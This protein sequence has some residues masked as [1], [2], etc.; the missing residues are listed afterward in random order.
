M[1]SETGDNQA[2]QSKNAVDNAE[3]SRQAALKEQRDQLERAREA[4][5]KG[6]FFDFI[7]DD[8]GV[9]GV[10]GLVTFNYAVVATSVAAHKSGALGDV[11][12][13]VVDVGAVATGRVD[14]LACDVLLRKTELSPQEARDVLEQCGVPRNAPGISDDDVKPL[15]RKVLTA[16]LMIA[17]LTAS[18]LSG[19]TAAGICIALAGL[20]ISTGGTYVAETNALDGVFG[21]GSSRWIGLGMEVYGAAASAMS[22]LAPGPTVV[23][24]GAARA[25]AATVAGGSTTLHGADQV[26]QA[27]N[28]FQS[29]SAN[30]AAEEA[31]AHLEWLGRFIDLVIDGL[32]EAQE[33]QKKAG[34]SLR[35]IAQT[36]NDTTASIATGM[37]V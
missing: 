6:G 13:D 30:A 37:R 34:D 12:I 33:S 3:T 21:K 16:N 11:K 9:A 23:P 22:G 10:V 1:M 25:V 28:A 17:G 26:M 8:L 32:K 35:A 31:K 5:K 7:A 4:A 19:G 36:A 27:Q 24:S 29:D 18:A 20:A 15:A 14:T 2:L